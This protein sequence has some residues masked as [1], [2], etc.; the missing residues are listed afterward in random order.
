MKNKF[1]T[2]RKINKL[3]IPGI[4]SMILSTIFTIAD[5]AIVGRIDV[6]GYTAVSMSAN[7]IYQVI[8]NLGAISIAFTILFA[9]SIGKK[10]EKASES[11][12]NTIISLSVIIGVGTEILAIFFGRALLQAIYGISGSI[13]IEA[14]SYLVISGLSIGIN[15]VCFVMSAFFKNLMEPK[16]ALIATTV[17]LPVNFVTDYILVFGK[18]GLPKLRGT[19]AAIGTIAGLF[20]EVAIF[21]VF[22]IKKSQ[23]HYHFRISRNVFKETIALLCWDRTSLKT[24]SLS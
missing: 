23:F 5:E 17:S 11:I 9:K 21:M 14:Y 8:G 22:F 4:L 1:D 12:F 3:A 24:P 7:I 20:V 13:L 15:L 18:L 2:I 10:D 16:I 6:D 19:G